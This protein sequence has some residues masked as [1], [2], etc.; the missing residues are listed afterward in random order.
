MPCTQNTK[1]IP[2]YNIARGCCSSFYIIRK[3]ETR[4]SWYSQCPSWRRHRRQQQGQCQGAAAGRPSGGH[5]PPTTAPSREQPRPAPPRHA[6]APDRVMA[7]TLGVL[8]CSMPRPVPC[9]RHTRTHEH[10][11]RGQ[12]S[13]NASHLC[14][15]LNTKTQTLTPT[16]TLHSLILSY[17]NKWYISNIPFYCLASM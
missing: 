1:H 8:M 9:C 16:D 4:A 17:V 11:R 10:T 2:Q 6:P 3:H 7:H 14:A 5:Q 15:L 13:P 12:T